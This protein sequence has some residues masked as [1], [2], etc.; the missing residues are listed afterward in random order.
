MIDQESLFEEYVKHSRASSSFSSAE[1]Q[2]YCNNIVKKS[3]NYIPQQ[4]VENSEE[5]KEI[6]F[7]HKN[8]FQ[9]NK[10]EIS[11]KNVDHS[12]KPSE[13]LQEEKQ[14]ITRKADN[15][16]DDQVEKKNEGR[17]VR[18]K[19]EKAIPVTNNIENKIILRRSET[20]KYEENEEE[21]EFSTMSDE[22][23]NRRVEE[24]IQR[25]NRQTRLQAAAR[26]F[27]QI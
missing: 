8:E 17:Y 25:F 12:E 4:E 6:I 20:E 10:L 5:K 2:Y 13:S 18:S 26:N 7:V 1:L 21:N 15:E 22:E 9:E 16:A 23:L 14:G 11:V 19:S 27:R 24:F 3:T